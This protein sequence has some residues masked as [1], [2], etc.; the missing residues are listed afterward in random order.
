MAGLILARTHVWAATPPTKATKSGLVI[1]LSTGSLTTALPRVP[2]TKRAGR[3]GPSRLEVVGQIELD[4]HVS[5]RRFHD[6]DFAV[7]A[8]L[9]LTP[10]KICEI[11]RRPSEQ[12]LCFADNRIQLVTDTIGATQWHKRA[13]QELSERLDAKT[14]LPSLLGDE[15]CHSIKCRTRHRRIGVITV[16]LSDKS[17]CFQ[18][19][20]TTVSKI[21]FNYFRILNHTEAWGR[22]PLRRQ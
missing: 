16:R 12:T 6:L 10:A 5:S 18:R 4:R 22:I 19:L 1:V 9:R 3:I 15:I 13:N 14:F 21:I 8:D 7:G 17:N 2:E 11:L 20:S